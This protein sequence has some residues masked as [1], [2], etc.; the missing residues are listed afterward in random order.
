MSSVSVVD[1]SYFDAHVRSKYSDVIGAKLG[2]KVIS[3]SDE[4]FA[5]ASNLLTAR[6]PIRD[7][8]RFTYNGAWYDGWETRR[9]NPEPADW[10]I[11]KVGV[12]SARLVACEIDTTFFDGNQAPAV[13]VEA[14]YSETEPEASTE[15]T[16]VLERT[17][18]RPSARQFFLRAAGETKDFYNYVRL[19]MYPDGGISR[20][21]LY[22]TPVPVFPAAIDTE[23]DLAHVSNGGVAIKCSDEHFGTVDN[24]LVS[25]R[26]VDMGDGWETTRSRVTGHEDWVIVKLGAKGVIDRIVVDTAFFR[27]NFPDKVR[28]EGSD[29]TSDEAV[30]DNGDWTVLVP[31]AKAAADFEHEFKISHDKPVSYVKLTMVPDG[32]IKR[33]RVYGRRVL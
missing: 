2:G 1:L 4:F 7:K 25:G 24:L 6:P 12:T 30:L 29:A 8:T 14:A 26:G 31:D 19:K 11:I 23:I 33:L 28:V 16:T 13:S 9:H 3:F 32:G 27:G 21:R 22:G 15:W 5:E 10:V 18:C 20:F 17:D